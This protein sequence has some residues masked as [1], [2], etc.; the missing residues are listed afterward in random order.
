MRPSLRPLQNNGF[1]DKDMGITTMHR[2]GR[3]CCWDHSWQLLEPRM[4][5]WDGFVS[6][7]PEGTNFTVS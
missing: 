1:L 3:D 5:A 7:S 2:P 6:D 4:Q